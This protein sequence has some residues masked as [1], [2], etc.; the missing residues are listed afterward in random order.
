MN[1]LWAG[2]GQTTSMLHQ[3]SAWRS[4]L[5]SKMGDP[6][7]MQQLPTAMDETMPPLTALQFRLGFFK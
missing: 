7:L 5:G 4:I 1:Q 3:I 2:G 6:V